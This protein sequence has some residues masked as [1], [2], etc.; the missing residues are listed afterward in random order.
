MSMRWGFTKEGPDRSRENTIIAVEF[1]LR[2]PSGVQQEIQMFPCS[3]TIDTEAYGRGPGG[4]EFEAIFT[5]HT[6]CGDQQVR[7]WV[8]L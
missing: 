3:H 1:T 6:S 4:R 8:R 5:L 7:G 2:D